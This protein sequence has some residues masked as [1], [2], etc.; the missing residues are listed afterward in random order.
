MKTYE[1]KRTIDGISVTVDG[2]PLDERRDIETFTQYGFEW[3]YEGASPR[4]L[5]LAILADHLGDDRR[6]VALSDAF[7]KA[8][9]AKLDNDWTLTSQEIDTAIQELQGGDGAPRRADPSAA[10]TTH[11]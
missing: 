2:E 11:R 4:Q 3:S 8:V 7:M 5:A 9:V 1:G 10:T 6:A